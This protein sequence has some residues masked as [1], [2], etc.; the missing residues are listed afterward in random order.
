M[1]EQIILGLSDEI[2]NRI[3]AI[4]Q[5]IGVT[6]EQLWP[7][8][9]KQ[10]YVEAIYPLVLVILFCILFFSYYNHIKNT[11]WDNESDLKSAI[12]VKLLIGI[13]AVCIFAFIVFIGEFSDI[14]NPEYWAF[15]NLIEMISK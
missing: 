11:D 8:L 5:K 14:F 6:V 10:Q 12:K 3:D 9:I 1:E 7:W 15:K 13:G 4:A 2:L